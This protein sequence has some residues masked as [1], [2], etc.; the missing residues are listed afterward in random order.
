MVATQ[1]EEVL[2]VLDLV[3]QEQA[4]SLQR[5]LATVDV[6]SKEEVIGFWR[7]S[8]ILKQAQQIVILTM[9]IAADLILS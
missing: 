8:T 9:Y 7:K 4:N 1:D 3:G 5:L 2:G 6:V